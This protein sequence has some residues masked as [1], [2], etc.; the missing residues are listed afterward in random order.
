MF[1]FYERFYCFHAILDSL[2]FIFIYFFTHSCISISISIS[3]PIVFHWFIQLQFYLFHFFFHLH[4]LNKHSSS[5]N[6]FHL[7]K[8]RPWQN[9]SFD[10][11]RLI[12][13]PFP[14][15]LGALSLLPS[16]LFVRKSRWSPLRP[17]LLLSTLGPH[18]PRWPLQSTPRGSRRPRRR[19]A[20]RPVPRHLRH[21]SIYDETPVQETH[22]GE[23]GA[24]TEVI[25]AVP[26]RF[27]GLGRR[28]GRD[29]EDFGGSEQTTT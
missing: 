22:G 21:P 17:P 5:F 1:I 6:I 14:R 26:L 3:I 8:H 27:L 7:R 13:A 11:F 4:F 10:P 28:L 29:A 15:R 16:R 25:R 18:S 20:A 23:D 2:T 19:V 24:A 9:A 12:P